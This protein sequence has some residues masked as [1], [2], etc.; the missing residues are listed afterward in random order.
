LVSPV[1]S[2][3][4]VLAL[5]ACLPADTAIAAN[6]DEASG[7][8]AISA[9]EKELARDPTNIEV[10]LR[11]ADVLMGQ[12]QYQKAVNILNDTLAMRPDSE[13]IKQKYRL[14][15]SLAEEQQSIKQLSSDT[16][17]AGTRNSV[18]EILC[19][20]L[21]GQRAINA[22]D[23]VLATNP[24]NITALTRRGDELMAL[25]QVEDAV[26]SYRSAV[27]L[28]P[29][30][31]TL[32]NK[33]TRAESKMSEESSTVVVEAPIVEVPIINEEEMRL[34]EEKRKADEVKRKEEAKKRLLA[35]Q[36]QKRKAD[37]V[38]RKEEA[39]KRLLAEQE[40][41]RKADEVK[42]KEEAKKRLLAEQEN[43]RKVAELKAEL[44]TS[45]PEV[46]AKYSNASLANGSTY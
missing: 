42:R 36:E 23:E 20:T 1:V 12:Q 10:R 38:K 44:Q 33:L 2:L 15:S 28:D 37:E 40:L 14:A 22:C 35:E 17:A 32:R 16:P 34:A 46:V 24:R 26:V 30:N 45:A 31:P 18:K 25:N 3:W 19:K 7:A 21:K 29:A 13:T 6:C 8:A 39:K 41:K 43:K 9:C 27:A 4:L 5:L 11:Y